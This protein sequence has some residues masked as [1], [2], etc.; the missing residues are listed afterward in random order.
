MAMAQHLDSRF[1]L[2]QPLFRRW[3]KITARQEVAGNRLGVAADK[4]P[5]RP[6]GLAEKVVLMRRFSVR[7]AKLRRTPARLVIREDRSSSCIYNDVF[8]V[9]AD[10]INRRLAANDAGSE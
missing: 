9:A 7:K 8:T 4:G 5:A 3:K 2:E 1:D 10:S 6:K